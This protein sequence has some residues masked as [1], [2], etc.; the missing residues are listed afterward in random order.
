MNTRSNKHSGFTLVEVLVGIL[1][2]AVGLMALTQLQGN[3]AK[4][5]ADANARTVAINLAEE[6]VEAARSFSQITATTTP[7]VSAFNNI[8]SGV[9]TETRG[10]INYEVTQ[11]VTDYYYDPLTESFWTTKPHVDIANADLKRVE[12]TVAWGAGENA[13]NFRIDDTATSGL[14]TGSITLVDLISTFTTSSGAKVALNTTVGGLYAPPIDYNPGQNPD[15]VSIQLGDNKFKESTTPLPDVVRA[16]E[17]VETRFDVVTYSQGEAGATFLRREEFRAV[18]CECALRLPSVEGDGGLRPTIWEGSEYT[19]AEFIS[20][21]FGESANNLQSDFCDLCC[22][23]HHDGGISADPDTKDDP[24]DPGRSRYSPFRLSSD[25]HTDGALAGDHK[26]YKRTQQGGLELAVNDGDV[27]LEACRMVRKDGFFR[28]A[29]DLRQ[30]GLNAFPADYLDQDA[31]VSEY[32]GYVTAA[33]AA[34]EDS[35]GDGYEQWTPPPALVKPANLNDLEGIDAPLVFPASTP[36]PEIRTTLPT[37][38]GAQWQ[39]LR[40]RGIYIDYMSDVLRGRIICLEGLAEGGTGAECDVP[41]VT[42]VLEVI[43]FYDVQLTWLS[44]WTETETNFPIDV[45]NEAIKT[46]NTHDR[47]IASQT[48]EGNSVINAAV[49]KGNLGLTGTDP[50]NLHYTSGIRSYNLYAMA[51]VDLEPPVSGSFVSGSITSAIPGLRAADVEIVGMN[52]EC[53]RT[54][55]GYKCYIPTGASNPRME[56]YNYIKGTKYLLA[57]A[58]LVV[59]GQEHVSTGAGNWTRFTLPVTNTADADIVIKETTCG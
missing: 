19:E 17:L 22:R 59:Q 27:Y 40:S 18:S 41:E 20:K 13:Q 55:T 36:D 37:L 34:F 12:L 26:H 21:P 50:I 7:G 2:F 24:Y 51:G 43:P 11:V 6:R 9:S 58:P 57:C 16:D 3:L 45:T 29:Q 46:D 38:S 39:Q 8:V 4:T 33:V 35:T 1:I 23:D 10:N 30:E 56:V 52:A 5:S 49:H 25:Y 28:I 14:G 32:S 48:G 31:E 47:G 15:I 42:S 44:R 53:N 54:N